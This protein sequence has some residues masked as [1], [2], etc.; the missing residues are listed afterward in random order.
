MGID[1]IRTKISDLDEQIVNL[2]VDRMK[3][4]SEVA[5]YKKENG[6]PVLNRTREREILTRV[7]NQ[8]GPD[9]EEYAKI[10]FSI[11]FDLSK[12]YQIRVLTEEGP[13]SGQIALAIE[14]TPK[15]FPTKATVACQGT[16]GAYSQLACDKLF[17]LPEIMYCRHFEGVFQAVESGLCRYGI[18]PIENSM[19]GSVRAVYDLMKDYRFHIARSV[20]MCVSHT[21]LAKPGVD[22]SQI[23]EIYSHE[24]ALGQCSEFFRTHKEIKASVCENT[25]IAAQLVSQSDRNDVAALSSKHCAELYGLNILSDTVQNS[26]N[27]YTRFI[28]IAKELEIYPGANRISIMMSLPHRPGSLYSMIARFAALGLNLTKLESRPIPGKDFEF[29]FYFDMDASVCSTDVLRLLSHFE[30]GTDQ[31]VFLGCYSE[32]P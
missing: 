15:T 24:Q 28:C 16:D 17:S 20:R 13:L 22:F 2:V 11:L 31:F 3:M 1:E 21:L 6:V 26:D 25:A 5:Q 23:R 4:A 30:N 7:T 19:Y 8:A 10:L 18:L 14:S 27:N 32:L 9:F 12:S 29:M